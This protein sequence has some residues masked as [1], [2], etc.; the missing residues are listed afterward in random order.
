MHSIRLAAILEMFFVSGIVYTFV[1]RSG[2]FLGSVRLGVCTLLLGPDKWLE[3][4][5]NEGMTR[6]CLYVS[7]PFGHTSGECRLTHFN[8]SCQSGVRK[9]A[10]KWI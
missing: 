2:S 8:R 9:K 10:Q 1:L 4:L 3:T 5:G 6:V 7:A